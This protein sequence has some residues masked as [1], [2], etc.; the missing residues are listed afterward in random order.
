MKKILL[1]IFL[2]TSLLPLYAEDKK[3]TSTHP[4][5][6]GFNKN[7]QKNLEQYL[8][9][10]ESSA[11]DEMMKQM[12]PDLDP[13]SLLKHFR[14]KFKGLFGNNSQTLPDNF[15]DDSN[16]MFENLLKQREEM[17]KSFGAQGFGGSS[18]FKISDIDVE[19]SEDKEFKYLNLDIKNVA[20]DGLKVD[21]KNGM[22]S[23]SGKIVEKNETKDKNGQ[24]FSQSISQF[25]R[26]FPIPDGVDAT[27]VDTVEKEGKLILKFPKKQKGL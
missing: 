16:A 10:G 4:S 27:K 13:S 12:S 6:D 14:E 17:L 24:S 11:S 20:K 3:A 26:S 5:L 23:I 18:F 22:V 9:G 8:N 19:E 7:Y 2:I 21:I 1:S 25:S 15:L